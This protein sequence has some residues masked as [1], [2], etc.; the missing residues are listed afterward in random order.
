MKQLR[1]ETDSRRMAS[2]LRTR[3]PYE[4]WLST[5]VTSKSTW[6]I[7]RSSSLSQRQE[8]KNLICDGTT[9][10]SPIWACP[11]RLAPLVPRALPCPLPVPQ[12][13]MCDTAL[14]PTMKT[15]SR[16]SLGTWNAM[17]LRTKYPAKRQAKLCVLDRVLLSANV[18]FLH[19]VP[20]TQEEMGAYRYPR[21]RVRQR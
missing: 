3:F 5:S 4:S 12:S 13:G 7:S 9:K 17:A 1:G 8:E 14:V 20:G 11:I 18:V 16:S 6:T 10:A 15:M 21:E 2:I 19:D